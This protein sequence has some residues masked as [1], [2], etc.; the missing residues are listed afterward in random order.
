MVAISSEIARLRSIL[1]ACRREFMTDTV[2]KQVQPGVDGVL[3]E[4]MKKQPQILR[5]VDRVLH[6][7]LAQDDDRQVSRHL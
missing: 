2:E 1:V 5:G 3:T 6:D 7:Q 4:S